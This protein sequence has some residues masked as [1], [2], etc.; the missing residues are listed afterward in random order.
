MWVCKC[1]I[2]LPSTGHPS[3]LFPY[4]R[5]KSSELILTDLRAGLRPLTHIGT[6]R[7]QPLELHPVPTCCLVN[8][9]YT[10][11]DLPMSFTALGSQTRVF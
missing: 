7:P 11:R 2:H 1:G 9:G 4:E 10:L 8:R 5:G 6:A 3:Q